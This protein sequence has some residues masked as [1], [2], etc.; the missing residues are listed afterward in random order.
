M[1]TT[2]KMQIRARLKRKMSCVKFK[3]I[4]H[5]TKGIHICKIIASG[6]IILENP[7]ALIS[8]ERLLKLMKR[9]NFVWF[10]E[11]NSYPK[12]A[13]PFLSSMPETNMHNHF[14]AIKPSVDWGKIAQVL[15]GLYRFR[16]NESDQ[17]FQKWATCECRKN[18]SKKPIISALEESANLVG[19]NIHK[20]W[21][22]NNHVQLRNCDLEILVDGSWSSL[23]YFDADAKIHQ[24]CGYGI[25]YFLT[26]S[27]KVRAEIGLV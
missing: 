24:K 15:G 25:D 3:S 5:Y 23:F 19:D 8:D 26:K 12:T 9:K 7:T 6:K 27:E 14:G 18:N 21:V 16:F 2:K 11:S 13:M 20:F 17:R 10:T 22:S 4:Y 1:S